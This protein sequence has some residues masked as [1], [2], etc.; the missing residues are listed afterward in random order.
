MA[1]N[2]LVDVLVQFSGMACPRKAIAQGISSIHGG[3]FAVAGV[4]TSANRRTVPQLSQ[5]R[6]Q[7]RPPPQLQPHARTGVRQTVSNGRPSVHGA[8]AS[9]ALSV[10]KSQQPARPGVL[11][12]VM[13]GPQSVLGEAVSSA[14]SAAR[15]AAWTR[16]TLRQMELLNASF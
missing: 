1:S 7:P 15:A 3:H 2:L 16:I 8:V 11:E 5:A 14:G 6:P 4:A 12:M 10:R 9:N 13:T